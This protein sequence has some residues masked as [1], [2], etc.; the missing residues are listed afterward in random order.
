MTG[1]GKASLQL[2]TKKI[3]VEVK[4]L[5]SKNLDL[6][7]RLPQAYR[8]KELPLRNVIALELERGKVDFSMF[9][10]V[11]A[12]ETSNKINGPIVM[13]YIQQ[14]K[15]LIPDADQTELMKMAVRMPDALKVE[16]QELDDNEW[17]QIQQVIQSALANIK[18]FRHSEGASLEKDFLIRIENI[19]SCM[20]Q[21]INLDV[22]RIITVKERLRTNL[23]E[24]QLNIDENRFEQEI[25]YYLEK[26]DITEEKVRLKK[27]L[28][29]F[30]ETLNGT[31]ANGRKLGFIAQE[32]GREINT[33]G[34]KSNH[35]E[36]QKLVVQM[37]DELEKIKEQVL[38]VL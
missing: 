5:N 29:Y 19:H 35:A 26:M 11:T 8:E 30:V 27:H 12:E 9:C 37:K 14:M 20:E 2:A 18:E 33:M 21:I 7:V 34:S 25:I 13:A 4:S 23:Q 1:F 32:M 16:R 22:E 38:N 24:L 17:Q 15:E 3:T 6:N 28:D 31:Q 10:E 36:M